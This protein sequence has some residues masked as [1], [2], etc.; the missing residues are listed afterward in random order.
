MESLPFILA[1]MVCNMINVQPAKQEATK[2]LYECGD[3][4]LKA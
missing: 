2:L 3:K 1:Y 4:T